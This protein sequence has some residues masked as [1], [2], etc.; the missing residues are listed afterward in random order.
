MTSHEYGTGS[1][2]TLA[3]YLTIY[4][5]TAQI[6]R[7]KVCTYGHLAYLAGKPNNSRQVGQA[8]KLLPRSEQSH[9]NSQNVPWWRVIGSGGKVT[10]IENKKL[11]TDLLNS[12]L[13]KSTETFNLNKFGWFPEVDDVDLDFTCIW[14]AGYPG[15]SSHDMYRSSNI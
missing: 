1:Q 15:Q 12:E 2:D 4:H 13:D 7:G 10:N 14:I 11:Q 9:Y 8:L 5:L 6:P 3:F